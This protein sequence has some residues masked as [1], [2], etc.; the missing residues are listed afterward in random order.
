M[1]SVSGGNSKSAAE[2]R[3]RGSAPGFGREQKRESSPKP[4][5]A[6]FKKSGITPEIHRA[7]HQ[8][9]AIKPVRRAG[10]EWGACFPSSKELRG[11]GVRAQVRV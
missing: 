8:A 11:L 7:G 6:L 2:R 5:P 9:G 4:Q 3:G 10:W 1:G